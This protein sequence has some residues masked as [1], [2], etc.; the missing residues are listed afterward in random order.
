MKLSKNIPTFVLC[1]GQST[2][3]EIPY[4]TKIIANKSNDMESE[5]VIMN[6]YE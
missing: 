3:N 1:L 6:M 5:E 4:P 2:E